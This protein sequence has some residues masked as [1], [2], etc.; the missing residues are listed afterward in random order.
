MRDVL[1]FR[2]RNRSSRSLDSPNQPAAL[3]KPMTNPHESEDGEHKRPEHAASMRS[4]HTHHVHTN[5]QGD[6]FVR[7]HKYERHERPIVTDARKRSPIIGSSAEVHVAR[8]NYAP[9]CPSP[10][11]V[12]PN[13]D[14]GLR[15][16]SKTTGIS[17]RWRADSTAN[18]AVVEAT[19]VVYHLPIGQIRARLYRPF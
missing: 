16:R 8:S 19:R 15:I 14:E 13:Y 2:A 4:R 1:N 10:F 6:S 9:G 12:S 11:H 3:S 5:A 7:F 18:S 17:G